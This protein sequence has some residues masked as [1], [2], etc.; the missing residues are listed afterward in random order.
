MFLLLMMTSS[1]LTPRALAAPCS[2]TPTQL[3]ERVDLAEQAYGLLDVEK[4]SESMQE[5]SLMLPCMS[6]VV[7]PGL[8]AHYLRILGVQ[9]FLGHANERADQVFSAARSIDPAYVF[10][11][12]LVPV[13]HPLRAHYAAVALS[14][15]HAA[16]VPKPLDSTL[17]FNGAAATERPG[18]PAIVQVVD[19]SAAVK[20]TAILFRE[21][22]LPAYD[23]APESSGRSGLRTTSA[24][25]SSS[26]TTVPSSRRTIGTVSCV[27]G[28][29]LSLGGGALAAA[30]FIGADPSEGTEAEW[31]SRQTK[32]AVGWG[33]AGLGLVGIG[34][35]VFELAHVKNT[36]LSIGPTGAELAVAL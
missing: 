16:P 15:L 25:G 6:A 32:N 19:A 35:G 14:S 5:A 34:L 10:P 20:S 29:A 1:V 22:G 12:S 2:I 21:D 7:P 9:Y 18:W 13:D 33:I 26:H 3:S 17:Y 8:A 11:E 31:R 4:F 23:L 30:T 36:T 27:S 24:A 28:A